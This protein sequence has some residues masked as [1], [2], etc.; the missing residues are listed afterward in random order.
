MITIEK[1]QGLVTNASPYAL[2]GGAAVTQTNLQCLRPG[3]VQGRPGVSSAATVTG[4]QVVVA[5]LICGGTQRVLC[6]AGTNLV[7]AAVT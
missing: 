1:W 6:Q 2:P 4:G 5:A 3:Q 7:V